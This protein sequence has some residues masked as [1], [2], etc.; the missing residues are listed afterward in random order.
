MS[1]VQLQ[2]IKINL[3]LQSCCAWDIDIGVRRR[4]RTGKKRKSQPRTVRLAFAQAPVYSSARQ[5]T[6][7]KEREKPA[8]SVR[9]AL[10][11]APVY[12]SARPRQHANMNINGRTHHFPHTASAPPTPSTSRPTSGFPRSLISASPG[13]RS[14]WVCVMTVEHVYRELSR[15]HQRGGGGAVMAGCYGCYGSTLPYSYAVRRH[16]NPSATETFEHWQGARIHN[17]EKFMAFFFSVPTPR[18]RGDSKSGVSL[19]Y[20]EGNGDVVVLR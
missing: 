14:I 3:R 5:S 8:Q 13:I 19:C 2:E 4:Q 12:S 1:H 7:K 18:F 10:E 15:V 16:P 20:P 6:G 9:V 17:H 11:Q